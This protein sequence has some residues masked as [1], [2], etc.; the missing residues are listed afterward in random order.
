MKRRNKC[1]IIDIHSHIL[2]GVDDG[3]DSIQTSLQMLK[4]AYDEGIRKIVATPHYHPG[5]CVVEYDELNNRFQEFRQKVSVACPR[6][7]LVLG[8]EL[9]YTSDVLESLE[10]GEKLTLG[11]SMYVLVEYEP[12][13]EY[14]LIYSS[15]NNILQTGHVPV[16]AH[17]ERYQ[18]IVK[19][20]E[21]VYELKEM[22]AAIQVNSASILGQ[23]GSKI[24]K[25]I[26]RLLKEELID[27]IGTD[28]HSNGHRAPKIAECAEYLYRKCG[29]DY[30][31]RL[32]HDN[33]QTILNGE[34]LED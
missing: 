32:L 17:I 10:K 29:E 18:C 14:T 19:Y 20:W 24:K 30:A 12:F 7:K 21:R 9:F 4:T 34:Y 27:V 6:M 1:D 28:A 15:L 23:Q 2:Y 26:K 13:V 16:I 25:F 3:S 22:G 8:R 11:D 5:K 31:Q 33:A